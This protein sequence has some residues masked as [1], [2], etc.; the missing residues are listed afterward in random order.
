MNEAYAPSFMGPLALIPE[1]AVLLG[2]I[3]SAKQ[4]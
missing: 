4:E 2:G 3:L 1:T